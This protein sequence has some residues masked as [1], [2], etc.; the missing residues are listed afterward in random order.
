M[1]N[2]TIRGDTEGTATATLRFYALVGEQTCEVARIQ[3][4]PGFL[5]GMTRVIAQ[6]LESTLLKPRQP[7]DK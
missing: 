6:A 1:C 7:T 5:R 2:L 3:T 4:S